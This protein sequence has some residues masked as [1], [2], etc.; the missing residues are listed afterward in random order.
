MA[1]RHDSP[2]GRLQPKYISLD[3]SLPVKAACQSC[4]SRHQKCD[5]MLPT[6]TR[7][8]R[9]SLTCRY[10]PSRRG[11][12][13]AHLHD[14]IGERGT[15]ANQ[16]KCSNT[17]DMQLQSLPNTSVNDSL[18]ALSP[19]K[20]FDILDFDGWHEAPAMIPQVSFSCEPAESAIVD[21]IRISMF[22][23]Y[24]W[25]S[26]PFLP[27]QNAIE[28]HLKRSRGSSLASMIDYLGAYML[29]YLNYPRLHTK[30]NEISCPNLFTAR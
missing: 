19:N 4:R 6:C 7:C 10:A 23:S 17:T 26:H 25:P 12:S 20:G 22:Y 29:S 18:P 16:M 11:R 27:P 5:G 8:R 30:T 28:P 13:T 21:P 2:R 14:R 3:R 1:A 9:E 24:L 15:V